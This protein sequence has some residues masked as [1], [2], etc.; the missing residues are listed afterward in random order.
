M[1]APT[2]GPARRS[3][4]RCNRV[5]AR[6]NHMLWELQALG[7]LAHRNLVRRNARAGKVAAL[8]LL[9]AFF[10]AGSLALTLPASALI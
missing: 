7:G 4:A 5:L 9:K 3:N 1:G 8:V 10:S 2:I 6:G